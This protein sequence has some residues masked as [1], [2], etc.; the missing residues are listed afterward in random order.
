MTRTDKATRLLIANG[1]DD[2]LATELPKLFIAN[3]FEKE[4]EKLSE[5]IDVFIDCVQNGSII[6]NENG[7]VNFAGIIKMEKQDFEDSCDGLFYNFDSHLTE[8][9]F[10]RIRR[11]PLR[12][13]L[14]NGGAFSNE[15]GY[16]R[17]S[18]PIVGSSQEYADLCEV[19][20]YN[21]NIN[22]VYIRANDLCTLLKEKGFSEDMI[23]IIWGEYGF[24]PRYPRTIKNEGI[25][26]NYNSIMN[27]GNIDEQKQK[28]I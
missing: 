9:F 11:L 27:L 4:Q 2:K 13:I 15:D 6:P 20:P 21:S 14:Q 16:L 26:I 5:A 25:Y 8:E 19:R 28:T 7:F 24:G 10:Y 23:S 3:F 18:K 1:Y 12:N 17:Y 22:G